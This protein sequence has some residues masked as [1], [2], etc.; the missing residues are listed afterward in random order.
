MNFEE[1]T[2][3]QMTGAWNLLAARARALG[4]ENYKD[5]ASQFHDRAQG[6]AR[7]AALASSVEALERGRQA[8]DEQDETSGQPPAAAEEE[9][10]GAPVTETAADH[11]QERQEEGVAKKHK[12]KAKKSETNGAARRA[13]GKPAGLVGDF[14]QVRAGSTRAA[15]L[16]AMTGKLTVEEA[17][18][19]V[20]VTRT[21]LLA[22]AHCLHRDCA[23]GY[24]VDEQG[25][26][27]ALYPGQRALADAVRAAE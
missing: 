4:S 24:A 22:H 21:Q 19:K 18:R 1:M 7:L 6:L 23:I 10:A 25:R 9:P 13:A 27:A 15:V 20:G 16:A 26:I 14:R 12:A 5:R 2:L 11:Q 3:P 8:A 17:A